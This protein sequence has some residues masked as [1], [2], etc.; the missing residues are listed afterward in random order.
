MVSLANSDNRATQSLA[1]GAPQLSSAGVDEQVAQ[2]PPTGSVL[3]DHIP[4]Q[5]TPTGREEDDATLAL[6]LSQLSPDEFEEEAARPCCT[7]SILAGG[8]LDSAT[9]LNESGEGDREQAPISS[10]LPADNV[11]GR[12]NEFSRQREPHMAVEDGLASSLTAMTLRKV[13]T[14]SCLS[15]EGC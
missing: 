9:L 14:T 5:P 11:G 12:V 6:R 2:P 3:A 13:R 7:E 10:Q 8:A 1:L 15:L 4:R